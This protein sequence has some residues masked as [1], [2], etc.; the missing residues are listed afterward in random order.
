MIFLEK[1]K[2]NSKDYTQLHILVEIYRVYTYICILLDLQKN[3]KPFI[4]KMVKLLEIH[5]SRK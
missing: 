1:R 2:Y 5:A 4:G 3:Q